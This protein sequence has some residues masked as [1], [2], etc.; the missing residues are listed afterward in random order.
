MGRPSTSA[1]SCPST[2]TRTMTHHM[3]GARRCRYGRRFVM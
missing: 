2:R 1:V 3:V